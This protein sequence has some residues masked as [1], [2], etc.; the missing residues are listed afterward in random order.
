[1]NGLIFVAEYE[2]RRYE[3]VKDSNVGFYVIRYEGLGPDT[4]HDYLQDNLEFAKECAL[5]QFGVPPHF[6]REASPGEGPA[7]EGISEN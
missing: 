1:M 2:G 5:D 7:Y 6:W 4:T 3:I